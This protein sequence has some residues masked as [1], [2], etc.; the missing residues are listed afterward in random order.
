M[1]KIAPEPVS[2][3]NLEAW[4]MYQE[5][6][7][8]GPKRTGTAGN[9]ELARMKERHRFERKKALSH[10]AKYGLP[11]LYIARH[12]L[13]AQQRAERLSLRSGRKKV[14]GGKP[15]FEN[16]LRSRG[17]EKEANCWRYRAAREEKGTLRPC[18]G[19]EKGG[20]YAE[21]CGFQKVCGCGE[22]GTLPRYLHKDGKDG[23]KKTF[24]L[25]RKGGMTRGFSLANWKRTCRKCCVS[26]GAA[27]I[28]T[29]RRCQ[30]TGIISSLTT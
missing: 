21:T 23:G 19:Q 8:G 29:T 4:K 7:A 17:M 26:S 5:E 24:I 20:N 25:D 9:A 16:W 28:F 6:F 15:R 18:R 10:L 22:C 2:S 30:M 14:R 13:L 12:C 1:G 11:V 27:K 3:V